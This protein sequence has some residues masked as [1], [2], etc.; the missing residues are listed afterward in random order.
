MNSPYVL[1]KRKIHKSPRHT[2]QLPTVIVKH[3]S[4]YRHQI[5]IYIYRKRNRNRID[6]WI[7]NSLSFSLFCSFALHFHFAKSKYQQQ[8]K[9]R[10]P[11]KSNIIYEWKSYRFNHL[12]FSMY[13]CVCSVCLYRIDRIR[14]ASI[15]FE[16]LKIS[17]DL[18]LKRKS[19]SLIL[20][21]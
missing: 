7:Y 2:K 9:S 5:Y 1:C 15:L 3:F 8:Q 11:L 19:I 12:Y 20:I 16:N 14:I 21:D 17:L 4:I 10:Y 13:M 6:G 18:T